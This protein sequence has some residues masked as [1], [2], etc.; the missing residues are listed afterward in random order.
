MKETKVYLLDG[1]TMALDRSY[2][3]LEAGLA[4]EER[5]PV[6]GVLIDHPDGKFLFDTGFDKDHVCKTAPFTKPQQ[7]ERQTLP[8]QLDLLKMRP[9]E[10]TH[11]INSHYHLDHCG[12]NKYC[13]C[14]TTVC[15]HLEL[16]AFSAPSESEMVGYS[17]TSFAP[18]LR[19]DYSAAQ[20]QDTAERAAETARKVEASA[21][22]IFTPRFETLGGDQEIAK[23]IHLFETLG[24]TAGHYSLM[25]TLA[26]RRPMLFTADACY[27]QKN[28]DMMCIQ[29]GNHDPEQARASLQRLKD[30]AEKY[31]AELFFSHDAESYKNY[32]KAPLPY[33]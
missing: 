12:G 2:L 6:Y 17:D 27:S 15:H 26:N 22:D 28:L 29:A 13:T 7:T 20:A 14:A 18:N 31:D 16:Q 25:V 1:G 23:G 21:M 10:I 4:G 33:L 30:L 19:R 11:V 5:F 8:G 24:H 3:F 9:S 32:R